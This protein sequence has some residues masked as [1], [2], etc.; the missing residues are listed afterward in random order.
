MIELSHKHLSVRYQCKLLKVN[1]SVVYYREKIP[2]DESEIMNRIH[3]IWLKLVLS[4]VLWNEVRA[5]KMSFKKGCLNAN[6]L[7]SITAKF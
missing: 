1:R 3:E 7:S 4:H 2:V 5:F 6:N